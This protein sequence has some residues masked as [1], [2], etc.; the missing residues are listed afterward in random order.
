MYIQFSD[1]IGNSRQELLYGFNRPDVAAILENSN[2]EN[3][4]FCFEGIYENGM[5]DTE[6]FL[7]FRWNGIVY[8]WNLGTIPG[9]QEQQ[10][11]SNKRIQI[12]NVTPFMLGCFR[13]KHPVCSYSENIYPQCKGDDMGKRK[14][15]T[16]G[17]LAGNFIEGCEH[18]GNYSSYRVQRNFASKGL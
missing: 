9:I 11:A 3:S 14:N 16:F 4:G 2:G 18:K 15:T 8:G 17:K 6:V 13:G 10:E 1:V 5:V 7:C 12:Q